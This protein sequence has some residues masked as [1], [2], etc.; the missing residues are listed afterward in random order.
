MQN[1]ESRRVSFTHYGNPLRGVLVR[2]AEG[3][4]TSEPQAHNTK[5]KGR[6]KPS[7]IP[8]FKILLFTLAGYF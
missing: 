2:S 6:S 4:N 3:L 7:L 5:E 1:Q 8:S